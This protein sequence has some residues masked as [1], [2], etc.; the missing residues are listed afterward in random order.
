MKVRVSGAYSLFVVLFLCLLEGVYGATNIVYCLDLYTVTNPL[1]YCSQTF[2]DSRVYP[3]SRGYAGLND[4][5][6]FLT[7]TWTKN[8][9][10]IETS[11]EIISTNVHIAVYGSVSC[12]AKVM[13]CAS[14]PTL[15]YATVTHF[16]IFAPSA[17]VAT[18]TSVQTITERDTVGG[19][20]VS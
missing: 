8:F 13:W 15:F 3:G 16:T 10:S 18:V 9:V 20:D 1:T 7:S 5:A 6:T 4:D 14:T 11:L 2:T 19:M 17:G 12:L